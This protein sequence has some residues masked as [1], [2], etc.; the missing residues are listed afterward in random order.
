MTDVVYGPCLVDIL[1]ALITLCTSRFAE[2]TAAGNVI[3]DSDPFGS[4]S[5]SL[6]LNIVPVVTG[7]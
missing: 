5:P 3:S 1:V 7:K 4:Q 2:A 6:A